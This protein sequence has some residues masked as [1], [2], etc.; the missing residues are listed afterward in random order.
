MLTAQLHRLGSDKLPRRKRL[1]ILPG[2]RFLFQIWEALQDL[3]TSPL[4]RGR[5]TTTTIWHLDAGEQGASMP[6]KP[7]KMTPRRETPPAAGKNHFKT[8]SVR[9]LAR[10]IGLPIARQSAEESCSKTARQAG[11]HSLG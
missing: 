11:K 2:G 1:P 3:R 4:D 7:R 8:G 9:S 5:S 10:C 6:S